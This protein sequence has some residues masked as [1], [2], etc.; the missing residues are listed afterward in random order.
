MAGPHPGKLFLPELV[1]PAANRVAGA[2]TEGGQGTLP[3]LSQLALGWVA[4]SVA[5]GGEHRG[6]AGA[7]ARLAERCG[8]SRSLKWRWTAGTP[9]CVRR[10]CLRAPAWPP[11]NPVSPHAALPPAPP[12]P[13]VLFPSGVAAGILGDLG[14]S[15][16]NLHAFGK[17][18]A[19][20]SSGCRGIVAVR[21]PR[22]EERGEEFGN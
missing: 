20:K 11:R 21:P 6:P 8:Q 19:Q 9:R 4:F 5:P 22:S 15:G 1:L 12:L 18:G 2:L 13:P 16:Q 7:R 10:F 17:E 14:M 3:L